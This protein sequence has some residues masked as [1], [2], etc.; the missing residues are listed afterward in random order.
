MADSNL[1]GFKELA[2]AMLQLAPRVARKRLRRAV[3]AGATVIK[4]DAKAR[5]PVATGEML[6]DIMVKRERDA[7]GGDLAATYSVFVRT[8]KKSR[9]AGKGRD[10]QRDSF[11][12]RFVELGTS[13]MVARPFMRPAYES[14]KVDAVRVIGESLAAGLIEEAQLLASGK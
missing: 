9:M 4:N 14:K 13:K 3:A 5:A 11:Y 8:G 7:R 10:V 12:W 1:S 6:R 2:A